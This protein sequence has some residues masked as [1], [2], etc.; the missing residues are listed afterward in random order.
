MPHTH[1]HTMKKTHAKFQN[2]RYKTVRR[3]ALTRSTH[4]LYIEGEKWLFTMWKTS[5]NKVSFQKGRLAKFYQWP[6][7]VHVYRNANAINHDPTV[8]STSFGKTFYAWCFI[9]NENIFFWLTVSYQ[10]TICHFP[11]LCFVLKYLT[12]I[13]LMAKNWSGL[14]KWFFWKV[15]LWNIYIFLFF[16]AEFELL[17]FHN[18]TV[19]IS[20]KLSNWEIVEH[21][22]PSYLPY[23]FLHNLHSFLLLEKTNIYIWFLLTDD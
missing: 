21:L 4:C 11:F 3:V 12:L 22:P 15:W 19:K 5:E 14:C 20:E 7:S 1:P 17:T 9:L 2:N 13:K 10:K 8:L 6:L 16:F 18:N 23:R